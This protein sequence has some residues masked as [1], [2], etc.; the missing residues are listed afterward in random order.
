MKNLRKTNETGRSMVEMLGVLAIVGVLSVGGVYGY[1]VA[2]KKHKANELLHQA[3]MLATTV[4]AQIDSLG[5]DLPETITDFG[6]NK[7]G[8]FSTTVTQTEDK[9]KFVLTI[10]NVDSSVCD[11]L[12]EGGMVRG[13]ECN[14][15]AKTAK[16]TYYKNLATDPAEGEKSPTG[17]AIVSGLATYCE[18][19]SCS[20][21][22]GRPCVD[23]GWTYNT[24]TEAISACEAI[25]GHIPTTSELKCNLTTNDCDVILG[26]IFWISDSTGEDG[27]AYGYNTGNLVK[28]RIEDLKD[29]LDPVAL[30]F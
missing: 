10:E 11:Q 12:K 26:S 15:E 14:P 2:M 30:C 27:T 3:S 9:K 25:G 23:L 17:E 16:I 22:D 8:N 20:E 29:W 4:S 7:Y 13:V 5:G 21:C 1:G 6:S 24:P 28:A 18:T 19:H